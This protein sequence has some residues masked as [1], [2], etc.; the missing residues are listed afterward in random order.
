[1]AEAR[2][3]RGRTHQVL[4]L[5]KKGFLVL[6]VFLL[7]SLLG[8]GGETPSL[9]RNLSDATIP[10]EDV[11]GKR[12]VLEVF[13]FGR[14]TLQENPAYFPDA[15]GKRNALGLLLFLPTDRSYFAAQ[16]RN[17]FEFQYEYCYALSEGSGERP[18]TFWQDG[19]EFGGWSQCGDCGFPLASGYR[20]GFF[21]PEGEVFS[22]DNW[23][24]LENSSLDPSKSFQ[25]HFF[26]KV[27]DVFV[28]RVWEVH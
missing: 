18:V 4:S 27:E 11:L 22:P 14:E 8:W 21:P 1:M 10:I 13:F 12:V 16:G 26:W 28:E 19:S 5:V 7:P 20:R 24:L 6:W 3:L 25:L 15:A 2:G 23:V 17:F 9:L